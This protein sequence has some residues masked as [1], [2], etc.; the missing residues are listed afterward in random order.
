MLDLGELQRDMGQDDDAVKTLS[1]LMTVERRVLDPEQ[2]EMAATRYDL[3]SILVCKGKT[4]KA[5]T[6]LMKRSTICLLE[7]LWAWRP[8][9]CLPCSMVIPVLQAW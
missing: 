1:G 6:H 4:A 8:I 2:G 7:S 3:A 5:L 9:P